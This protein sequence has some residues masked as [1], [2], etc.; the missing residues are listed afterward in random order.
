MIPCNK[1]E[2]SLPEADL[3]ALRSFFASL[4]AG[5]QGFRNC[6]NMLAQ[7]SHLRE[8]TQW[9]VQVENICDVVA[10]PPKL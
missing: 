2:A 10:Q 9:L 8:R 5:V 1:N 6:P 3:L 7:L 4:P